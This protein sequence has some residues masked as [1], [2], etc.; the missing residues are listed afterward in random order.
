MG[1][2][3][4]Y[5]QAHS[6]EVETSQAQVGKG[7]SNLSPFP[8]HVWH[9]P[10]RQRGEPPVLRDPFKDSSPLMWRVQRQTGDRP[11]Q[12]QSQRSLNSK[13]AGR[14]V[15]RSLSPPFLRRP[16][17]EDSFKSQPHSQVSKGCPSLCPSHSQA[18]KHSREVPPSTTSPCFSLHHRT[19]ARR[20]SGEVGGPPH[21]LHTHCLGW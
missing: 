12:D 5:H 1:Q 8:A 18:V 13:A 21:T 3:N 15:D 14:P 16:D 20:I 19:R 2:G 7:V 6:R 9:F 10:E 11:S 4:G 17:Y